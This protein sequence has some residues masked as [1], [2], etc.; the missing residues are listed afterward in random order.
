MNQEEVC[1]SRPIHGEGMGVEDGRIPDSSVTSSSSYDARRYTAS[2][3]RL[4]SGSSPAWIARLD[5]I[6]KWVKVSPN[7]N[8]ND[9]FVCPGKPQQSFS[10]KVVH[11]PAPPLSV[12]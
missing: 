1:C 2:D 6:D 8:Y 11:F 10:L 3:G 5:D 7:T 4:N 9:N 12:I